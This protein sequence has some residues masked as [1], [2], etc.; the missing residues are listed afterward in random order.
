MERR[1]RG[2]GIGGVIVS[3]IRAERA[4]YLPSINVHLHDRHKGES[5]AIVKAMAG[6]SMSGRIYKAIGRC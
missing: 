4:T 6:W 5:A 1:R 2:C 3:S